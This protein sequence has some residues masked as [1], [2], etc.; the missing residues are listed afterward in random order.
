M[1]APRWAEM[2]Y[3]DVQ[4][5]TN[6]FEVGVRQNLMQCHVKKSSSS[7]RLLRVGLHMIHSTF[8]PSQL[9][10]S[11]SPQIHGIHIPKEKLLLSKQARNRV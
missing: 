10:F 7:H 6:R 8:R 11:L 2:S 4:S 3:A 9:R 5:I 1:I